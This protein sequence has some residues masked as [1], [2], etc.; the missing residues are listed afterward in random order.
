MIAPVLRTPV[1]VVGAGVAGSVLALELAL[2]DVPSIVVERASRPQ[3]HPDLNLVPGRSMELLRRLGLAT[4]IRKHGIDP[5]FPTDVIWS[6]GL[7]QQPVLVS[8]VPSVNQLRREYATIQDGSTPVEPYLLLPGAELAAGLRDAV[9]SHPLIDLREG[10]T[11]TDLRLE[12]DGAVATVLEAGTGIRHVIEA[13]YLAGCDGAQSTVRRCL[14]V[15]MQQLT[16]PAHH[17]TVYFRSPD[18]ARRSERPATIIAAG[19]TLAWSQDRDFWIGQLPLDPDEATVTDAA[20]LLHDRLGIG[21]EAPQVLGVVQWDDALGVATAYRRGAAYL[22]GESAHR[23]AP[24]G[25]TVDTCIG[26]AVDLGWKLAAAINGW[27]G[28]TLLSSYEGER[29]RRALVDRELLARTLETRRRFGR[30]AAVG[31][32]REFLADVLR[33]EPPLVETAGTG[34]TGGAAPSPVVWREARDCRTRRTASTTRPGVRPPAVRLP[35]GEQL[36]DRLGPQFTLVDLTDDATGTPLVRSA[37]ARGI[38]MT[39]L[40]VTDAAVRASWASR[41]VLVRPD[42]HI[43]WR[44]DDTP[45]DWEVVLGVVTGHQTQDH[46]NA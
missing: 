45:S 42:Q 4:E 29:R 35:D 11:F 28:P 38:P 39:H 6:R 10:W 1:L 40:T 31:A 27:G 43:A 25:A 44:T 37:R 14:G 32:S 8:Q 20:K 17:Y 34:L 19:I 3:R 30:L 26:D 18:L 5:D 13:G 41:L 21:L 16:A 33:Q 12:Q 22:A 24:P 46:L 23:F 2:H 9:R 36:F 15:S 7:D